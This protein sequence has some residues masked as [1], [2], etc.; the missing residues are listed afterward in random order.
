[1]MAGV[2]ENSL[3]LLEVVVGGRERLVGVEIGAVVV[4]RVVVKVAVRRG[5]KRCLGNMMVPIFAPR[6]HGVQVILQSSSEVG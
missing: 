6:V 5:L 2:D 3:A 1:M 4:T